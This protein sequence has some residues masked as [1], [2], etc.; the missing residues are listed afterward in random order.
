MDALPRPNR[1]S[2]LWAFERI[3]R[4][5]RVLRAGTYLAASASLHNAQVRRPAGT[6]GAGVKP[7]RRRIGQPWTF[8]A[9]VGN[10]GSNLRTGRRG[11]LSK[12]VVG[13]ADGEN[14]SQRGT[15]HARPRVRSDLQPQ[16][17]LGHPRAKFAQVMNTYP[18]PVASTGETRKQRQVNT[19]GIADIRLS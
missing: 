6:Y 1:F 4:R 13:Q 18:R 7:A 16:N 9:T 15:I 11:W 12:A 19:S 5:K 17:Q 8:G 2:A 14:R 3:R 10:L